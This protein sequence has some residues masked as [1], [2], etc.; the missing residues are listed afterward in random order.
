MVWGCESPELLITESLAFHDR[1]VKDT[2]KDS[3]GKKI[4][5]NLGDDTTMDQ[6]R[7][8]QGSLFLEFYCPRSRKE[9]NPIAPRELY[10]VD[11][12]TGE[13]ALDLARMA[14]AAGGVRMPVWQVALSRSHH[15]GAP[16]GPVVNPQD[17][18]NTK[19]DSVSFQ[20]DDM[21]LF[22]SLTPES[23]DI[24]RYIW[25][26]NENP[27][28]VGIGEDDARRIYWN[29]SGD[30]DAQIRPCSY[31]VVGPRQETRIGSQNP[32]APV[33]PPEYLPSE[34][35]I[36]LT[37]SQVQYFASD[38]TDRTP[39]LS[40]VKSAQTIVAAANPPS[41]AISP[42]PWVN[43]SQTAPFGIGVNVTE[44]LPGADYYQEPTAS[45]S[46]AN[47][48]PFDSYYDYDSATGLFPTE[49]FDSESAR[50]LAVDG[51]LA[52]KTTQNYKTAFLQRLANPLLPW[53]PL[54]PNPANR[55][56]EP[57]NPYITV[58]WI[59]IDVTV[60]NGEDR[61]GDPDPDDPDPETPAFE[62]R[63]RAGANLNLW[64]L[65]TDP[66][67]A[68]TAAGSSDYF[69]YNVIHSLGYLNEPFGTA[70]VN[71]PDGATL[72]LGSTAPTPEYVGDPAAGPFPW[73]TWN[74]RPFASA[75][76]LMLV[77]A[78][79]AGRLLHEYSFSASAQIPY[80]TV[81]PATN[82][83]EN[84]HAPFGH[85][86]NFYHS[87]LTAHTSGSAPI[88]FY[89]DSA[90]F[91]RIF[92]FVDVPSR[93]V[94]TEKWYNATQFQP[95]GNAPDDEWTE[96]FRPP[97]NKLSRFRDPGKININT[98]F[99]EA[100]TS[101][102]IWQALTYNF[103]DPTAPSYWRT[104]WQRVV[105]SRLGMAPGDSIDNYPT[106]FAGVFRN[107]VFGDLAPPTYDPDGVTPPNPNDRLR[108][109]GV[110]ATLLRS[111]NSKDPAAPGAPLFRVDGPNVTQPYRNQD[112]NPYFYY[113]G[114][115]RLRNLLT[116]HSNVYAV[117]ITVGYFEVEPNTPWGS[118]SG[119]PAVVDSAH[120]D[121]FQLGGEVGEDSGTVQRHRAFYII[122]RSIPVAFE[123]GEN[124][125][126]DRAVVLRRFI[127]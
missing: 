102:Q 121:G 76:E 90:D 52:T 71:H 18:R 110:Q 58:D 39:A 109:Y 62:S 13:F 48:F 85:L 113:E 1:R 9:N 66:P 51:I 10:N 77:P 15:P 61:S 54:P 25:F 29:R 108:Q 4:G 16:G 92:D 97:F 100:G 32:V 126:V 21:S 33:L 24:E 60:F 103:P 35:R 42:E 68:S 36:L 119:T 88:H 63:E 84:F 74:N 95:S 14:P 122:D 82:E 120:P 57:I 65:D 11:P 114:I 37:P 34:Q 93:F 86:L 49:P 19:P 116:T 17:L 43:V 72:V 123:P 107:S 87:D 56:A 20:P 96:T 118:P 23:L 26:A 6:Y 101:D 111:T 55:P 41:P 44:P 98:I 12:S 45:L 73:L 31:A 106:G 79:S 81:P 47:G 8:P 46:A 80:H 64:S 91:Y 83:Y 125:N 105:D 70:G 115:E 53:N 28:S 3:T 67:S 104:A 5:Q 7:I 127:E 40:L 2:D 69:T 112:R 30:S 89:S 99:G 75:F 22:S 94:G 78:S 38:G 117:W 50:P 27:T 59:P 124:H